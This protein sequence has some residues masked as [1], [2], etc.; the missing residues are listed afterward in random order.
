[1]G[2]IV[3]LA[4]KR[5]KNTL[6][7]FVR[8][9]AK[10]VMLIISAALIIGLIILGAFIRAGR[11]G[12]FVS[13]NFFKGIFF[14]YTALFVII[15]AQKGLDSGG[16]I[17]D[18]SDVNLLF[19]APVSPKKALI[20]G[21]AFNMSKTAL[22]SSFL[23]LFQSGSLSYFGIGFGGLLLTLFFCFLGMI[24]SFTL[25]QVIYSFSNSN[26]KRKLVIKIIL[27]VLFM[28]LAIQALMLWRTGLAVMELLERLCDSP[29][30]SAIP[31]AGWVT[32]SCVGFLSGNIIS[33]V[34]FLGLMV[35]AFTG[36]TLFLVFGKVDFYE[37]VLCATE[38]A[39]DALESNISKAMESGKKVRVKKTGLVGVGAAAFFHRHL[40]EA[41]RRNIL[42]LSSNVSLLLIGGSVLYALILNSL[43]GNDTYSTFINVFSA[44]LLMQIFTVLYSE[45]LKE[46]YMPY[47]YLTP[48]RSVSK[49]LWSNMTAFL[50]SLIEGVFIFVAVG[51]ILRASVSVVCIAASGYALFSLKLIAFNYVSLRWA[52]FNMS[53]GVLRLLYAFIV[54]L[55]SVPGVIIGIIVGV[56]IGGVLGNF[57]GL[58]IFCAWELLVGVVCFVLS[59]GILDNCDMPLV[60]NWKG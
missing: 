42:G 14:A 32:A 35:L 13:I 37:D 26:E 4:R 1:M 25:S 17:F 36:F 27:G 30:M 38:R 31:I 28:P 51:A 52:G 19:T 7:E 46:L 3:Y 15:T 54:A 16:T 12:S 9:P 55:S 45:G 29:F 5:I 23:I 49:I 53:A 44:L 6:A 20:Y 56:T 60:K 2:C 47:I 8:A 43:L 39:R 24:L 50:R 41:S 48:E 10:L 59:A 40:R 22:R 34:C 33:G 18:M 57:I 58:L 21:M 11:E